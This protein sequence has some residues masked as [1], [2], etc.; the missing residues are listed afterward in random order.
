MASIGSVRQTPNPP[1]ALFQ[2]A[3]DRQTTVGRGH[4]TVVADYHFA[5]PA[6]LKRKFELNTLCFH[7]VGGP[8]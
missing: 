7:G 4:G 8:L 2:A 5:A 3:Q 1:K 6:I